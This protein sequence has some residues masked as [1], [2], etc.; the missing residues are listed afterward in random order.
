MTN[1]VR[2]R[3]TSAGLLLVA[4][5][6]SGC[7]ENG[8]VPDIPVG[9]FRADI[10]GTVSDSLTGAARYRMEGDTL[11]GLELGTKRGEGLSIQVEARPLAVRRYE[12]VE[13]GL[14]GTA[15]P[16]GPPG[17]LSFLTIDGAQFEA[18][19]G[20]LEITYVGTAQVGATFAFQM[21]GDFETIPSD[22]PSVEVAGE[23]N[24]RPEQ[25][26]FWPDRL[27]SLGSTGVFSD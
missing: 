24:A 25:G 12:I 27:R 22:A 7:G 13:A 3:L 1:T 2:W 23:V 11:V 26:R 4:L 6:G 9:Q 8:N 15:R 19:G 21:E 18:K 17:A 14:F 20:T 16:G 10:D 5:L